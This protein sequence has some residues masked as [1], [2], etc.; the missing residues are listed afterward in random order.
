MKTSEGDKYRD[1]IQKGSENKV[2]NLFAGGGV[3]CNEDMAEDTYNTK[4][5]AID[6]LANLT[7]NMGGIASDVE[8]VLLK[9][10]ALFFSLTQ[11][12][13]FMPVPENFIIRIPMER[14]RF[15]IIMVM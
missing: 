8:E 4:E 12:E 3:S 5:V 13:I 6:M 14:K 2:L 1:F 10:G 9:T 7:M 15:C 11:P